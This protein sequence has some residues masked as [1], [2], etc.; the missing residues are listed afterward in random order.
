M[1][2][3]PNWTTDP[4]GSTRI[5][6]RT[7]FHPWSKLK[8]SHLTGPGNEPRRCP[9]FRRAVSRRGVIQLWR[10]HDSDA[11]SSELDHGSS[12]IDTDPKPHGLSSVFIRGQQTKPPPLTAP[13]ADGRITFHCRWRL[14]PATAPQRP[15]SS[16]APTAS[17]AAARSRSATKETPEFPSPTG[18]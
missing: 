9:F 18:R 14:A 15:P 8:A 5:R 11:P 4:H 1:R 6:S 10:R 2:P 12:R 17:P 7:A 13:R 16:P 3:V